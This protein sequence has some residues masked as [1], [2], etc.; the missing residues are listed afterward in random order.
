MTLNHRG[1]TDITPAT[2]ITGFEVF[3]NGSSVA[4]QSGVRYA[5]DAVR[6]TLTSSIAAGHTVTLRY[7][8]GMTPDVSGL[9][10]DNSA[11]LALPLENTTADVTVNEPPVAAPTISSL[12]PPPAPLRGQLVTIAGTNF[13]GAT[14][15]TFGGL[16]AHHHRWPP[17][18]S[19]PPLRLMPPAPWTWW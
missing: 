16:N 7:L 6:L 14:G 10:K 18:G 17:P 2:G 11:P 5:S 15:V 3:D 8:Y 13:T 9:V 4:I 12:T 1:G 19:P